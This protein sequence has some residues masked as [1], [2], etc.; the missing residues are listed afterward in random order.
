MVGDD[1][2][3]LGGRG[4]GGGGGL[5]LEGEKTRGTVFG[6]DGEEHAVTER[7]ESELGASTSNPDEPTFPERRKGK[8]PTRAE[9]GSWVGQHGLIDEV[10][11][12]CPLSSTSLAT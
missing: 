8:R 12:L 4:V 5:L 11:P 7:T 2:R 3:V 10:T 6:T 1:L 9:K